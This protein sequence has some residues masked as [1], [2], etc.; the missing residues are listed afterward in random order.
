MHFFMLNNK[1]YLNWIINYMFKIQCLRR[2]IIKMILGV[3][4]TLKW[5][6]KLFLKMLLF[7]RKLF[8]GIVTT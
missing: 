3:I 6:I 4:L 8:S 5:L 2:S 7:M 1:I